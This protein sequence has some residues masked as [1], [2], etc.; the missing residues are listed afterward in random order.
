M[1]NNML[2]E[3]SEEN[4]HKLMK[5]YTTVAQKAMEML[6]SK[7]PADR[8]KA[9]E[10]LHEI[11]NQL[12]ETIYSLADKIGLPKDQIEKMVTDPAAFLSPEAMKNFQ[13]LQ[14]L[15]KK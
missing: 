1:E 10:N 4:T 9:L 11:K 14:T 12:I 3:F 5:H 13:A 8:E 7:D 6:Q 15:E 2:K